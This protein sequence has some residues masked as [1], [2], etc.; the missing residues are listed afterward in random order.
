MVTCM[1]SV[2]ELFFTIPSLTFF[3]DFS[4]LASTIPYFH[5]SDDCR[6]LSPD[7]LHLIVCVHGLDGNSADLRLIKTYLE[8]GLPGANLD[9]LM[10]ERNQVS[11]NTSFV[12][13]FGICYLYNFIEQDIK[14]VCHLI[15]T[16]NGNKT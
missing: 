7:G 14:Q 8:I 2:C 16:I 15:T 3:S 12:Y 1:C 10:S 11:L 5:V 13:K 9:F 4:G 6:V